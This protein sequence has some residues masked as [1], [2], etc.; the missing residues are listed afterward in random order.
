[1]T[2]RQSPFQATLRGMALAALT[3]GFAA[4]VQAQDVVFL[5]TQLR[6]IEE[7]QKVREIVLKGFPQKVNFVAEEPAKLTIRVAAGR[8]ECPRQDR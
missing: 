2:S 5:S 7:A 6:P 8:D 1:M 4:S 3:M